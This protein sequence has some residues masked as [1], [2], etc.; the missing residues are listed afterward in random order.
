MIDDFRGEYRWMSNFHLC[1]VIYEGV[2]YPS[3]ENAYQ[4][5]KFEDLNFR[6][7][8]VTCS[9]AE[10]K[11]LGRSPGIVSNWDSIKLSVMEKLLRQKFAPGTELAQKLLDTGD[12]ELV[13]GNWWN[14]TFWGVCRGRGENHLGKL[15]MKLR[16]E[17]RELPD[18]KDEDDYRWAWNQ[19]R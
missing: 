2:T 3:V 5:A 9:P 6:R 4:A 12:E 13:E 14:D 1:R 19:G 18:P 10:S 8:F 16:Q 15:L 17:L 11:R 7:K